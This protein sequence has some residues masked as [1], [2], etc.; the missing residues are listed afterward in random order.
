MR[1]LAK[2]DVDALVTLFGKAEPAPAAPGAGAGSP[3]HAASPTDESPGKKAQA[4]TLLDAKR[5]Q[6]INIV[7]SQFG[8]APVGDIRRAIVTLDEEAVSLDAL[9]SLHKCVATPEEIELARDFDG[10][11]SALGRADQFLL[12]VGVLPALAPRLTAWLY[13]RRFFIAL[14]EISPGIST[15]TGACKAIAES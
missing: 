6:N 14:S 4:V 9:P 2:L 15:V 10:D 1:V 8:R 3:G 5:S 12:E 13:K 7:L 11:S